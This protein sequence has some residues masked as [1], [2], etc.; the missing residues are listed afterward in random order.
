MLLR[1]LPFTAGTTSYSAT[2][3]RDVVKERLHFI[4][5][6]PEIWHASVVVLGE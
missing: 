5:L 2:F 6:Q 1:T 3:L 4:V